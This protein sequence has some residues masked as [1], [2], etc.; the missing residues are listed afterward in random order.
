MRARIYVEGEGPGEEVMRGLAG[1]TGTAA[2]VRR[3][4]AGWEVESGPILC[5]V[6]G[7]MEPTHGPRLGWMRALLEEMVLPL[8]G[9]HRVTGVTFHG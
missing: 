2:E 3:T 4:G 9:Q 8:H 6:A 7:D 1:R 5:P